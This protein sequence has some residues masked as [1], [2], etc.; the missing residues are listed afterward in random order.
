MEP[1]PPEPAPPE[2]APTAPFALAADP[3]VWVGGDGVSGAAPLP[4]AGPRETGTGWRW[5]RVVAGAAL[6]ALGLRACV[7]EAYRIP[8]TSMDETLRPGDYVFVSKVHYG[9]RVPQTLGLPFTDARLVLPVPDGW[10]VPGPVPLRR[11]DVAVF[12]VPT[13]AGPVEMRTPYVKRVIGLPG[14]TVALE[15]KTAVVNGV[16]EVRAPEGRQFWLVSLAEGGA[17]PPLDSLLAMGLDGRVDRVS[18]RE[19]LVEATPGEAERLAASP[20]VDLVIPFVRGQRDGSAAFPASLG[21][22]LDDWGPLVVPRVGMTIA[23]DDATW[24]VYR[25]AI[26]RHEG[27]VPERTA[28]GFLL[29]GEPAERYTFR[30]DYL[31]VIGDHRD[32]SADSRTWGFVPTSDVIGKALLVYFSWDPQTGEPRW[33]R[34]LTPIR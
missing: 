2:A 11:G 28:G 25:D 6:L 30:H 18:D 34:A 13:Q 19:R 4:P 9:P 12:H 26:R 17:L 7:F 31:V 27:V 8:S 29:D 21:Y 24:P 3:T 20:G 16:R 5:L 10:R 14:D 22:S 33:E 1:R 15:G 32:D 23:L